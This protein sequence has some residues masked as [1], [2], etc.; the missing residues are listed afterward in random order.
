MSEA[1]CFNCG[2]NH[3][4]GPFRIDPPGCG[5]TDCILG[6]SL[7]EDEQH[8]R[9]RL[10]PAAQAVLEAAVKWQDK[11]DDDW[12]GCGREQQDLYDAIRRYRETLG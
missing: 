3:A 8:K 9:P 5:C 11:Y 1:K 4:A 2:R 7:P 12:E 10:T 6:C